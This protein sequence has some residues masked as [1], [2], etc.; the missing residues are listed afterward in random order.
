MNEVKDKRTSK[1]KSVYDGRILNIKELSPVER[2]TYIVLEKFA[3]NETKKSFPSLDTI[4]EL[5]GTTRKTTIKCLKKL[6][7]TNLISVEERYHESGSRNSNLYTLHDFDHEETQADKECRNYTGECSSY[8]GECNSYTQTIVNT[9]KPL[10]TKDTNIIAKAIIPKKQGTLFVLPEK[11]MLDDQKKKTASEKSL[12]KIADAKAKADW[13]KINPTDFTYYYIDQHNKY[14]FD[15]ISFI[16]SVSVPC[17]KASILSQDIP[18]ELT[19]RV[20]QEVLHQYHKTNT[21]M[22]FNKLTFRMLQNKPIQEMIKRAIIEVIPI[23]RK[24]GQYAE[25]QDLS[26]VKIRRDVTF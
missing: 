24:Y 15:P 5:T 19:C 17:L 11:D 22:K 21:N 1:G 18:I 9:K 16:P 26:D 23:K 12:A 2:L 20:I 6:Q 10:N 3:N 25:K 8:T 4:A 13:S 14:D 7:D